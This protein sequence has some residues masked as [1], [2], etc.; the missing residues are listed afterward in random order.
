MTVTQ[1][2]AELYTRYEEITR[3]A[4]DLQYASAVLGWDQE[5]YMPSKGYPYR[6]RQMATLASMAHDMVTGDNYGSLLKERSG[7]GDLTD[8]QQQNVR[9]S[10]EDFEKNNKLP[11]AFIEELTQQTSTSYNAWM[12]A[13][14]ENNYSIYA[15]QLEKMIELKKRQADLYGYKGHPYDALLDDYEKGANVVMLD[16]V[17]DDVKAQLSPLL[18]KIK[19]AAQVDDRFYLQHFP[20][21]QQ[22]DF[23]IEVLKSM[24]YDFDAGRQDFS[25]HPF[26]TSF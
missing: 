19:E 6:G 4:A 10:L 21:Q 7:R 1:N 12:Q 2:S 9:L 18:D 5:V 15:P 13:R 8:V 26:T 3:K 16:K 14:K 23:S 11:S 17:F 25:E 20:K 24:G 22:W